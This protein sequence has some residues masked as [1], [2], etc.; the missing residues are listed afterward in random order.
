MTV[1]TPGDG[2]STTIAAY[3]WVVD[4]KNDAARAF[5]ERY[6]FRPFPPRR[7]WTRETIPR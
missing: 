7:R 2:A 3:A 4:A 6:G 1:T 5:Y